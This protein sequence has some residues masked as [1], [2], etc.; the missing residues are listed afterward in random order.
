MPIRRPMLVGKTTISHLNRN[1]GKTSHPK[2]NMGKKR[3]PKRNAI[4]KISH[5]TRN[6]EKTRRGV[7]VEKAKASHRTRNMERLRPEED[8]II[9]NHMERPR[10]RADAIIRNRP[11]QLQFQVWS[12]FFTENVCHQ[13]KRHLLRVRVFNLFSLN[14]NTPK[15]IKPAL[16]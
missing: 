13:N 4:K 1:M 16:L 5:R 11:S 15:V 10:P 7:A 12:H 14:T 6:T 2:R 3:H 8:T 9:R